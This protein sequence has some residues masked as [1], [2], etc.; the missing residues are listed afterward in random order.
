MHTYLYFLKRVRDKMATLGRTKIATLGRRVFS[1]ERILPSNSISVKISFGVRNHQRLHSMS[2]IS[3]PSHCRVL[4]GTPLFGNTPSSQT[5]FLT[6]STKPRSLDVEKVI[7]VKKAPEKAPTMIQRFLGPKK[8]PE[9]H[10]AAWYKEVLL[11]CTV[12]AI[13]G[14]STM[15]VSINAQ[16]M[17]FATSLL[18]L[19]QQLFL[20]VIVRSASSQRRIR[21][22]RNY[23][24]W[25]MVI[26]YLFYRGYES[27]LFDSLSSCWNYFRSSCIFSALCCKNAE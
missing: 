27:C 4:R 20:F 5:R 24:R 8:M 11:I 13:T 7:R 26:S 21:Y 3:L 23:E 14:S 9:R 12:F 2:A 25:S 6:P 22:R 18:M 1:L 15:V 19:F 10:T 17:F 16:E